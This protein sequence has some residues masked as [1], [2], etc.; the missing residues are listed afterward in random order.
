MN[1]NGNYELSDQKKEIN[2]H[3]FFMRKAISNY[4][5]RN[6]PKMDKLNKRLPM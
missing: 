1:K 3:E 4:K 2:V 5:F 6:T